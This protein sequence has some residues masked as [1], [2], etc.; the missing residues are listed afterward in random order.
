[1]K[2]LVPVTILLLLI[3]YSCYSKQQQLA[4]QTTYEKTVEL[5]YLLHL[6]E[7][8]DVDAEK[9]WPLILFLHGAGERGT[10]LN[11]VRNHS[12]PRKVDADPDFPFVVISPQCPVGQSWDPVVLHLLLVDSIEKYKIDESRVYL[13]GLSMGGYGTWALACEHPEL[14]AAIAPICGGGTPGLA[15][16]LA[17]IPTW[18]FHGEDDQAVPIQKSEEMVSALKN[19]G[20]DVRFTRFENTGHDSWT[21]AYSNDELYLWFLRH[22][23]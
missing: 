2:R 14:F 4:F 10:D 17:D 5:D 19:A 18:V 22:S 7:G 23:K 21:K 8:Y 11:K 3:S 15:N 9:E 20:G 6:P 16:K 13:T 1:M 12:L